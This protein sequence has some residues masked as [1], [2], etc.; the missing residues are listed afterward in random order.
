MT[1]EL[2]SYTG[3]GSEFL[4]G[5]ERVNHG[6]GEY[7]RDGVH[8]NTA[9]SYFALVKR[10]VVGA[11]HHTSKRHLGRYLFETDFRWSNRKVDDVARVLIALTTVK[12]KRLTYRPLTAAAA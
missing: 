9:E 11:W 1:D 10:A 4:G 3:I 2:S 6:D 12:G 7:S 8:T 5:H